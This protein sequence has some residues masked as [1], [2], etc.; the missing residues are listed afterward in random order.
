M[1]SLVYRTRLAMNRNKEF[2]SNLKRYTYH[3]NCLFG[4]EFQ[5]I[6]YALLA[7]ECKVRNLEINDR[8]I[9]R[10]ARQHIQRG[11]NILTNKNKI[12]SLEGLVRLAV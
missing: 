12:T 7:H 10:L 9:S 1:G 5:N 6:Y 8:N 4:G 2:I 3:P 11:A